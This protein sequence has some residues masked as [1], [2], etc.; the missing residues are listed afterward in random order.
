MYIVIVG[1][2]TVGYGLALELMKFP[3]HEVVLVENDPARVDELRDELGEMVVLG[4]GTEVVFLEQAGAGRADLLVAVT[5]DD[6]RNL[7]ACQVGKHWFHVDRTIARVNDP[8]NEPLFKTLGIDATVSVAAAAL[9]Q[10]ETSLPE[11]IVVPLMRL[12][13]SGLEIVNL[14]V[15]QES[16][17]EGTAI[18]DLALPYGTVISLVVGIDGSPRIPTAETVFQ[19]GDEAIAVIDQEAEGQVRAIFAGPHMTDADADTDAGPAVDSD[20]GPGGA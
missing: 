2:G 4:D 10:I 14:H 12:Q 11:H 20:A 3:D 16:E 8:R 5:R 1:A 15:Q 18:K 6:G 13:G 9:A 17:A 19:A 7:V